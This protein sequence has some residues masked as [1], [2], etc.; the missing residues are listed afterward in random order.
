MV[1]TRNAFKLPFEA[2]LENSVNASLFPPQTVQSHKSEMIL[3]VSNKVLHLAGK[4]K[5]TGNVASQSK[6]SKRYSW[7]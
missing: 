7:S 1:E 2:S 5:N 4:L 6:W 3:V